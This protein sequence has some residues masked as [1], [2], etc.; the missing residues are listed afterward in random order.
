MGLYSLQSVTAK[1]S[2]TASLP[3]GLTRRPRAAEA[4]PSAGERLDNQTVQRLRRTST[5]AGGASFAVNDQTPTQSGGLDEK[6]MQGG[7][8]SVAQQADGKDIDLGEKTPQSSNT[9][10]VDRVEPA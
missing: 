3:P 8:P 1:E 6:F 9:P 7:E 5:R 4:G 2:S 10:V